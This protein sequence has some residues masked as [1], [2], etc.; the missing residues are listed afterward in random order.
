MKIANFFFLG[1]NIQF[2]QLCLVCTFWFKRRKKKKLRMALLCYISIYF[3]CIEISIL[4]YVIHVEFFL[5]FS[6]CL[7]PTEETKGKK[8]NNNILRSEWTNF[9]N[10]FFYSFTDAFSSV[11][12][13]SFCFL[14]LV[15][16]LYL[17][18]TACACFV[19]LFVIK[20]VL[21]KWQTNNS[22]KYWFEK[23]YWWCCCCC[24]WHYNCHRRRCTI[25]HA[26]KLSDNVFIDSMLL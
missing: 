14:F 9:E 7:H 8:N 2:G 5:R 22:R 1:L 24:H 4:D 16:C 20:F 21:L 19:F 11:L 10:W 23:C 3:Y 18:R 26:P 25:T 12:F 15:T 17:T 13:L 6:F